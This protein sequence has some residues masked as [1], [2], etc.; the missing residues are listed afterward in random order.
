MLEMQRRVQAYWNAKPCDW[1]LSAAH[2]LT[3][4][5][6]L[7]VQ[8]ERYRLQPHIPALIARYDWAGKRVLEVG[9]GV[10]TDARQ[11]IQRGAIYTGINADAGS[12]LASATALQTFRLPGR[13]L[14]MDATDMDFRDAS[15]D[16]VYTFGVLHHIPDAE[17]TMREIMRVLR[18]GG[19]VLAMLYNR[20]SINYAVEI[21]VLRKLG[22]RLLGLPGAVEL[23]AAL[24]L[25]RRKLERHREL[26]RARMSED[27]WL[28]RNTDGPDNPY[29][30]VY[31]AAE[32]AALFAGFDIKWQEILFFN[33]EHWG[34]LG[35][36]LP[37]PL[38]QALGRSWGWHRVVYARKPA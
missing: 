23:L 1:D 25:P 32:A 15:F 14:Q 17:G 12:T 13:V 8:A 36:A 21:Q 28:S 7:E 33:H 22:V 3:P 5:F 24:G 26:A 29:S 38:L 10:G 27:E 6:F 9:T 4:T 30:K 18:P 20:S 16:F 34:V 31:D 35:R 11:L 19:E 2:A 37:Q